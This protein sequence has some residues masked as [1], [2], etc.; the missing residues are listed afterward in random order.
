MKLL[1]RICVL[2]MSLINNITTNLLSI[3]KY[4]KNNRGSITYA[5]KNYT[6]VGENQSLQP[7][8]LKLLK[9]NGFKH[10]KLSSVFFLLTR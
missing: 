7:Q 1:V 4:L 9:S 6:H 8:Y 5:N 10:D 3:V 2:W